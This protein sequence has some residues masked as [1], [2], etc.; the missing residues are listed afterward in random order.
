MQQ[1]RPNERQA[2]LNIQRYLRQL[3]FDYPAIPAPPMDGIFESVTERALRSYQAM[4]GLPDTGRADLTTWT[5][6]FEDYNDSLARNT[7]GRGFPAFPREPSGY[8]LALNDRYFL[9][10]IVQYMLNELRIL[11]DDIP[12]NG[13]SGIYDELTA[14]GVAVFQRRHGLA[15]TGRVDLAT[16]NALVEEY[17]RLNDRNEQ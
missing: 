5:R 11:Y 2:I 17:G 13:R 15:A 12:Q 6:L 3:S 7:R 14:Q 8:E 4:K 10:E 1:Q 9:V 16:W